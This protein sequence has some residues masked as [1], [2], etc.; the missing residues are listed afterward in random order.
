MG[1]ACTKF[2]TPVTGGNVSFYNQS[3]DEGPVFPTPTIG[4]LGVMDD[5]A[6]IMGSDF[7]QPDDLIYLIGE[8]VNDIA[9]SQYLASYHKVSASPAPYFDIDKE[10]ATHQVIKQLI[11]HKI[12]QS[13][14]DVADGGLFITLVESAMP[15]GVGFDVATDSG[16]RKD[17]FLFGEAQGRIV[18]SVAPADQ[19]RFIELMATSETEFSLLGTVTHEGNLFVD[20]E[21]FGNIQDIKLVYDNVL[22]VILGE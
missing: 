9:S 17:A 4:M 20:E 15:N 14:H 16:I 18:V 8:S 22:H 7:K 12:I 19:E 2:E 21:R 13:A 1:E 5:I 10:Y 3:S 11:S 6:N